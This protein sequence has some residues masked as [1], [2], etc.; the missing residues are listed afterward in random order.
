[1]FHR[2]CV[3]VT[4]EG[5]GRK[6][7]DFPA[8]FGG[9][10]GAKADASPVGRLFRVRERRAVFRKRHGEFVRQMRMTAA[11]AA[12]LRKAEMGFLARIVDSARRVFRDALRQASAEIRA[13]H[14]PG[15]LGL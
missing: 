15:Y 4:L 8:A 9:F 11:V 12:A 10:M 5:E 2:R 7:D 13:A 3:V 1:M 6:L 14:G